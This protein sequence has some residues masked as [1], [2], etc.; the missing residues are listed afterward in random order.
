MEDIPTETRRVS[1]TYE[2]SETPRSDELQTSL[3]DS[4][5]NITMLEF[6]LHNPRLMGPKVLIYRSDSTIGLSRSNKRIMG[7]KFEAAL[8]STLTDLGSVYS[9]MLENMHV[10]RGLASKENF[11]PE[12]MISSTPLL[13]L[14]IG[15]I[16]HPVY[17][18]GFLR[19]SLLNP[20]K[21]LFL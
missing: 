4:P 18:V 15:G 9:M 11:E 19:L 13:G 6:H 17:V 1:Y 10:K 7:N 14:K 2:L 20:R 3:G 8:K 5:E 16:R 12:E 21:P